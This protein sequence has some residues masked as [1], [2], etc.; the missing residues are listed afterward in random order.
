MEFLILGPL[1]VV[2][3]DEPIQLGGPKQRAVLGHLIPASQ[4]SPDRRR[5]VYL[6]RSDGG[7][8]FH[9]GLGAEPSWRPD[10]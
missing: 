4:R 9:V 3:G 5:D 8:I 1:E 10:D 6:M 2:A 7:Q